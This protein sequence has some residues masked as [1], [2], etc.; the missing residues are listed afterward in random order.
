MRIAG[1]ELSASAVADI[2]ARLEHAGHS[3]LAHR[4]GTAIDTLH[5]VRLRAA[6]HGVLLSL[7]E[8]C[9]PGLE[10]LREALLR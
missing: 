7:L 4:I 5:P 8:P 1:I 6:D 3:D 10:V 9:P 2:A